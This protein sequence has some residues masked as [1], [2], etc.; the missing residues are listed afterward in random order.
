[1]TQEAPAPPSE[2]RGAVLTD[3]RKRSRS[4]RR[5]SDPRV[6]WRRVGWLF[7]CYALYLSARALPANFKSKFFPRSP[8]SSS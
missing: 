7:A 1:V 2:R 4:G 5:S 6:N 3:R 8:G